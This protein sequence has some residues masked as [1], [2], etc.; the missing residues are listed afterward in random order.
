MGFSIRSYKAAAVTTDNTK[1]NT[2][3]KGKFVSVLTYLSTM[4]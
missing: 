2:S 3:K 4:P 1:K